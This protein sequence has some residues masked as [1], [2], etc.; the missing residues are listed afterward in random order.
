[1]LNLQKR[2]GKRSFVVVPTFMEIASLLDF[3]WKQVIFVLGIS[4]DQFNEILSQILTYPPYLVNHVSC[5]YSIRLLFTINNTSLGSCMVV[6]FVY[7]AL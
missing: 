7:I 3:C 6:Y 4:N 2:K 1:M 5:I